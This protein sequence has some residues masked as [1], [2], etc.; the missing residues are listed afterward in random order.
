M[1]NSWNCVNIGVH[2]D[3]NQGEQCQLQNYIFGFIYLLLLLP[4]LVI[5]CLILTTSVTDFEGDCGQG[6]G[7]CGCTCN[8]GFAICKNRRESISTVETVE[9]YAVGY[10]RLVCTKT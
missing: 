6:M 1:Q 5:Q 9:I 3:P 4:P 10:N 2:L 7:N 8:T